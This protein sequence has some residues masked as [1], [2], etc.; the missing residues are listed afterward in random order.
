MTQV[1]GNSSV[2]RIKDS[3]RAA[4]R[5]L[6]TRE[7]TFDSVIWRLILEHRPEVARAVYK[8]FGQPDEP[9]QAAEAPETD[10]GLI[11]D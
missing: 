8:G 9:G 10:A 1:A 7:E 3:T 5:A 4:L 11:D 6:R 2:I